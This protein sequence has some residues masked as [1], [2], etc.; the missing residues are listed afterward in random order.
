M[1]VTESR[2]Y[3]LNGPLG[4][5]YKVEG[6]IL[7]PKKFNCVEEKDFRLPTSEHVFMYLKALCFNDIV[8]AKKIMEVKSPG[9]AKKIGRQVSG[10]NE[11]KWLEA[12]EEAM[13][14]A[15]YLKGKSDPDFLRFLCSDEFRNHSFVEANPN[16]RIWSCGY[17]IDDHSSCDQ[18][19]E[20]W[21]GL[22]LLGKILTDLRDK[23]IEKMDSKK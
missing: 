12:R 18:P 21:P 20:Y 8:S 19:E 5:W 9:E 17:S 14:I 4:N 7:V 10:F 13:R 15:V 23:H 16:D 22:N 1:R 2:V 6:G 3:F 11:K